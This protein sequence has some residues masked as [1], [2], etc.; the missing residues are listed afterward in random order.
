MRQPTPPAASRGRSNI[1]VSFT[2]SFVARAREYGP[3]TVVTR[4]VQLDG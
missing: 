1:S 4:Q 3:D 2:R